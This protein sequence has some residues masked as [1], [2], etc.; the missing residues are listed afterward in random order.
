MYGPTCIFWANLTPFSL[1]AWLVHGDDVAPRR[2]GGE[3]GLG[4]ADARD[5]PERAAAGG[6]QAGPRAGQQRSGEKDAELAQKLGQLQHFIAVFPQEC[7]GQ[8]AY[9]GV[10]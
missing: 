8:L 3:A 7:M 5:L 9:F 2:A 1:Q 4:R 6:S 10:T